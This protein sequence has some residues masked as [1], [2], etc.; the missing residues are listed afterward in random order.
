MDT[1]IMP[2]WTVRQDK[3][4]DNH[5]F[6]SHVKHSSIV[7]NSVEGAIYWV[8]GSGELYSFALC[9]H[10]STNKAAAWERPLWIMCILQLTLASIVHWL[11]K[12][13]VIWQW[14]GG[15]Y[16]EMVQNLLGASR[17]FDVSL[18]PNKHQDNNKSGAVLPGSTAF[19]T[20]A[21]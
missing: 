21:L 2:S 14:V 11:P 1:T 10:N 15:I 19:V 7:L 16:D 3:L 20:E 13:W 9:A 18:F 8:S 4:K 12:S 5:S 6:L 17:P